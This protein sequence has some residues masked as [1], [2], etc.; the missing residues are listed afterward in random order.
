MSGP[1]HREPSIDDSHVEVTSDAVTI[2]NEA[3]QTSHTTRNDID[4]DREE[5]RWCCGESEL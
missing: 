1:D 3:D 4:G 2:R 5:I